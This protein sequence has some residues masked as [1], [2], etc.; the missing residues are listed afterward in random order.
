MCYHNT[1]VCVTSK[2]PCGARF[3]YRP[4]FASAPDCGSPYMDRLISTYM[5]PFFAFCCNLYCRMICSVNADKGICMYSYQSKI[6][7]R[8]IFLMSL[9]ICLTLMVLMMLFNNIFDVVRSTAFV[10]SYPGYFMRLTPA[11]I[12]MR[13]GSVFCVR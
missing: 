7:H 6:V 13:S 11:E 8:Y 3:S 10:V 9:H 12:L 4:L 2:Y 1:G 5:Y